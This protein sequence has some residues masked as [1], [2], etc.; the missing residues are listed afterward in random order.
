[1]TPAKLVKA[2]LQEISWDDS[3]QTTDGAKV[4]P[5]QFNP[6]TLKV[7]FSNQ[8]VSGDQRGAAAMQFVGTG[9]TK[10]AFDLWFDVTN[11]EHVLVDR[12]EHTLIV[13]P[14]AGTPKGTALPDD[15][16]ALTKDVVHFI[17]PGK[18]NRGTAREPKYIPPGVRF[19]WGTFKFEGI[20]ES[21]TESLEYF[22]ADGRPLRAK[23]SLSLTRQEIQ[24]VAPKQGAAAKPPQQAQDGDSA[25]SLKGKA[26]GDPAGWQSMAA[27][28]GIENPRRLA[29]GTMVDVSAGASGGIGGSVGGGIGFGVQAGVAGGAGIAGSVGGGIGGSVG[30]GI[31]GGLRGGIS[32]GSGGGASGGVGTG[33][34]GSIGGALSGGASGTTA[35]GIS[36]GLTGGAAASASARA[37]A[38]FDSS[39]RR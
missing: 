2:I 28:N 27:A 3:G 4:V 39:L 18:D 7:S 30:G 34:S 37:S 1:M 32:G 12:A 24:F 10:L 5:V 29:V 23:I 20:V 22:S 13:D 16:R 14:K 15:V 25:A 26:S 21:I 19:L 36:A 31:G 8:V 17:T 33:R 35:G 6:D 38:S 9:T 11:P